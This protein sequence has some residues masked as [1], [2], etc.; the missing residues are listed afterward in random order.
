MFAVLKSIDFS[1]TAKR[2]N[3]KFV[4]PTKGG[5]YNNKTVRQQIHNVGGTPLE[6]AEAAA[7]EYLYAP[8]FASGQ[9]LVATMLDS[10]LFQTFLNPAILD[11]VKLLCGIRYQKSV[12]MLKQL[13]LDPSY[14]CYIDVPEEYEV[15]LVNSIQ[16]SVL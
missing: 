1:R 13:R 10:I 7:F 4:R 12:E 14:L 15:S 8:S 3:I 11:V 2:N 5:T 6:V 16:E 9:V